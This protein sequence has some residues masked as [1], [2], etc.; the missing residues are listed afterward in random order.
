MLKHTRI[1]NTFE[2][3]D[4]ISYKCPSPSKMW[5]TITRNVNDWMEDLKS[6]KD[7]NERKN[8][9]A[10]GP[11]GDWWSRYWGT[12]ASPIKGFCTEYARLGT[13]KSQKIVVFL[14][15]KST[16]LLKTWVFHEKLKLLK[17]IKAIKKLT[18]TDLYMNHMG[19]GTGPPQ[20]NFAKM[21]I[22]YLI[23]TY[24]SD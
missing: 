14:I 19:G 15:K 9:D 20:A 7:F 12:S 8:G 16:Y 2:L 6:E 5:D 11:L 18:C 10:P 13:L 17:N 21:A 23:L 24:F 4:L 1:W 22:N 3:T